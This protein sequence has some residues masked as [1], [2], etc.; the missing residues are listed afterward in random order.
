MTIEV[1]SLRSPLQSRLIADFTNGSIPASSIVY[2]SGSPNATGRAYTYDERG[3]GISFTGGTSAQYASFK[4]EPHQTTPGTTIDFSNGE[5]LAIEMEWPEGTGAVYD[6]VIVYITEETGTTY[7]H[8]MNRTPISGAE[9]TPKRQII[10]QALNTDTWTRSSGGPTNMAT[11]GKIDFRLGVHAN[12]QNIP[13][14]VFIRKIWIGKNR[15]H[16]M[17]TFDDSMDGQINIAYPS[18]AAAGFKATIFS[19][20]SQVGLAGRLT[21]ADYQTLYAAGWDFG[22]Q[23]YNDSADVPL[24]F[25][26]T[27][28]LTSDGA[29]TATWS[30]VSGLAHGLTTG[31]T[32]TISGAMSPNYNG[33]FTVTVTG[34]STFTFPI[35]GT[36]TTPDPGWATI[37]KLTDAQILSSFSQTRDWL[38]ARGLSRGNEF[39]AYSN[40]VTN[41][42]VEDLLINAGYKMGRS[43]RL[44]T[45]AGM[46]PRCSPPQALM[47][48]SG[49]PMDQQTATT[50]LGYVDTCIKYGK[51][52]ILY[53]H[54]LDATPATL[55]ITQSEWDLLVAG[56]KLR[57]SQGL[58]DVVTCTE[59][60]RRLNSQVRY[61]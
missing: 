41:S 42:A 59:F 53:G 1:G 37:P 52:L 22:L 23:Q 38:Q 29:G 5:V 40:G 31:D 33:T 19:S 58:I 13:A 26:G 21:E 9:K 30:N 24:I 48:M 36:P 17:M 35:S 12:A 44:N 11:I 4:Y 16:I 8:Y 43:T 60:Y 14:N 45:Q 6:T 15:P 25:A 55:T 46:D 49:G 20:P 32:V 61:V 34:A 3:V 7:S 54:D 10:L 50:I 56:L 18:L 39:I 47:R 2:N 51:S 57:Q 27:T 28:G